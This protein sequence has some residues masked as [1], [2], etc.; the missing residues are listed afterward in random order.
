[1]TSGIPDTSL[2]S[3]YLNIIDFLLSLL[4]FNTLLLIDYQYTMHIM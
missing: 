2:L 4:H 1:M 3:F